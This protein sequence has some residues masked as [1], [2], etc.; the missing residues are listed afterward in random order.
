VKKKVYVLRNGKKPG[1]SYEWLEFYEKIKDMTWVDYAIF[2]Y[3]TELINADADVENSF[4]YANAMA[5]NFLAEVD[6]DEGEFEYDSDNTAPFEESIYDRKQRKKME[7]KELVLKTNQLA[8]FLKIK[9]IGQDNAIELLEKAYFHNEKDGASRKGPRNVFL[10]AGPPGVG[11]TYTAELFANK[12]GLPY[13]RFDMSEYASRQA[14]QGLEGFERTWKDAQ[15]GVLTEFVK[16]NP[17]CVLLFDE[18]E[19]A[20][21]TVIRMFLQILDDGRCTDKFY[22][23]VVSFNECIIFFTTNAGRQLYQDAQNENLS[24]LSTKVIVDALEKDMD[25]HEKRPL[26]PPELVSRLSSH[27]IIMFNHL[28]ASDIRKVIQMDIKRIVKSTRMNY[29]IF[30]SGIDVLAAT[31]QY[32]I[33]GSKDARNASKIAGKVLDEDVIHDLLLLINEK[34]SL[35]EKNFPNEVRLSC[36]FNGVSDEIIQFYNGERDGVIPIFADLDYLF[37]EEDSIPSI[38]IDNNISIMVTTKAEEFR[39]ILDSKNVLFAIIDFNMGRDRNDRTL[40]ILDAN[41]DGH[42]MFFETVGR[43]REIPIYIINDKTGYEYTPSEIIG[44]KNAGAVDFIDIEDFNESIVQIYNDV[45]CDRAVDILQS[46]HQVMLFDTKKEFNEKE[47]YADV[48]FYNLRLENAVD[49]EDKG[50]L[51]SDDLRPNKHWDDIYVSD[52]VKK[53]LKFFI[54]YLSNP[55]AYAKMGVSAPKGALMYGPPGTGKTSLAKV[56]ATEAGINFLAFSG[57]Q[58]AGKGDYIVHEL[59]RRARKYAPAVL[60]IDEIDALGLRRDIRAGNSAL[61]ALLTE[62][63]GF[64]GKGDKPIFVMAAT[65]LKNQLDLALQRR[66]D[67]NFFVDLPKS[68]GREWILKRLINANKSRFD[69][70]D[71]EINNLVIRSAGMSPSALEKVVELALRESIRVGRNVDDD[72]LD[73]SFEKLSYGDRNETD[74]NEEIL[75]VAYHEAGHAIIQ[76]SCGSIPEYMSIVSRGGFGGYV[77]PQKMDSHPSKEKLIDR[78][79]VSLGGRASEMEFGYGITPGASSDLE[80]AT[81][82]A[83]KMVCEYGMYEEEAGLMVI[84]KEDLKNYPDIIKLINRILSEQLARARGIVAD[85]R[86]V[87]KAL[88]DAVMGNE[89]KYLNRKDMDKIWRKANELSE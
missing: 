12:I 85:N 83:R 55:K 21:I 39:H 3:D 73:D 17:K 16:K 7:L 13:K 29:S 79:C 78:I 42:D 45:C 14:E 24:L 32:S 50:L 59:F 67:R 75:L 27:T 84:P 70:S 38:F 40:S 26:F 64:S 80:N 53:E 43:H 31:A 82:L 34:N 63:D 52:D 36:D 46:R 88:V 33:G 37:E 15:P 1:V 60:F 5:Q 28:K 4:A 11:K 72:I 22:D 18:I 48:I 68:E 6:Y 8:D 47:R 77:L 10:F 19:K 66:F 76:L 74:S 2:T 71:N 86:D 30:V 51:I 23:E 61:N 89:K 44:I 81:E 54:D 56:V 41:S 20:Y 87:I 25:V 9:V 58:L 49:A 35:T 65:N 69:I 57:D 62:M